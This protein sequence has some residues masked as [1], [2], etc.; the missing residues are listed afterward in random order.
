MHCGTPESRNFK[1]SLGFKLHNAINFKEQTVLESI[2]DSF[3]GENMQ[4][5]YSALGYILAI[6]ISNRN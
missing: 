1:K 3:V 4:T 5:Q 2:K 6:Q